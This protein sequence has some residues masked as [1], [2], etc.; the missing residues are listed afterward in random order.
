MQAQMKLIEALE[1]LREQQPA[2]GQT[3]RARL[4][5]GF[6]P[7]H[8]ETFF[9]AQL[10]SM[11]ADRRIEI[12]SGLYGDF[13]GNLDRIETAAADVGIVVMEWG[14]LDPRLG[15]RSLGSW[16][17]SFLSE[18]L[19]NVKART[20][21][22]AEVT[23]KVSRNTPVVISLPTLPLLP[24]SFSPGWQ[25]SVFD[26]E[27]RASM[28][29]LGLKMAEI[30]NVK[31]LNSERLDRLSPPDNRLDVK[32]ELA[33]G[34]PYKL[35]HASTVAQLMSH[36]ISP[37]PPKKGL[38][39]DLDDTFW[40]GILGEVGV[41][42]VFWDLEHHSQHH[43][44]YQRLLHALSEAGVLIAAA[45]KNDPQLVN[46]ALDRNDL[47]LSR[48]ALYP[49]EAH[50]G[51]KS[52]SVSRILKTWNIGADSVAFL[53]DSPMELAEVKASHPGVECILFP[54]DDPQA[55]VGLLHHL[56]D[57]FGKSALSE[58]DS[59]RRESIRLR[60]EKAAEIESRHGNLEDFLAQADAEL[61][62]NFSKEPQDPRA[63]ELVNKTNQF[64]LNGRTYTQAAW[65]TYIRQPDTFLLVAGYKDKYGPLGKIAVL[66]GKHREKT[67]RVDTWVMSCRAFS[68]RIEHRCIDELFRRYQAD[69][70]IFDF[71][72]TAKNG[73]ICEFLTHILGAKPEPRCVLSREQFLA[74]E[75]ETFHRVLE[76]SNG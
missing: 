36:M 30:A 3:F 53:D 70:M 18:I 6:T 75:E 60:Q 38:I 64:N 41:D 12:L 37:V 45:T 21:R 55:L 25:A 27:L 28:S 72:A 51:P 48:D 74:L 31:V 65:Q 13:W 8:L 43:G 23:E 57:L 17:P 76:V 35:A 1:I 5:C 42:R 44:L 39:T 29:S 73:P 19:E 33:S 9:S 67:I 7:L 52:E 2:H 59:I 34:F 46:K 26:L 50:W 58:E 71:Q 16:N 20:S 15:L 56:R 63:L 61:T 14:D 54:K 10:R 68:R 69:E 49:V 40:S 66:A 22:F 24:I 47:I 11:L 4:V 32:S 62:L